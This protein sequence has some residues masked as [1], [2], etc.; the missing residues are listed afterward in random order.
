MGLVPLSILCLGG[1]GD[2]KAICS[3]KVNFFFLGTVC[4]G[5]G[6]SF[7]E[8]ILICWCINR[9][10]WEASNASCRGWRIGSSEQTVN[11][12]FCAECAFVVEGV[13]FMEASVCTNI[14]FDAKGPYR[15]QRGP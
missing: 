12:V 10:F 5:F 3:S 1:G 7:V 8:I 13:F 15:L 9:S 2:F 14:I 6:G 11:C 4:C